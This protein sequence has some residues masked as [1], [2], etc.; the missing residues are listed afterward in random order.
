L[1]LFNFLWS[2][3]LQPLSFT[4]FRNSRPFA[5]FADKKS[6]ATLSP[7]GPPAIIRRMVEQFRLWGGLLLCLLGFALAFR[8]IGNGGILKSSGE[9]VARRKIAAGLFFSLTGFAGAILF[10]AALLR[11]FR[12]SYSEAMEEPI[13]ATVWLAIL[14]L[15]AFVPIA[16]MKAKT[17]VIADALAVPLLGSMLDSAWRA[18]WGGNIRDLTVGMIPSGSG[19]VF[20]PLIALVSFFI[21]RSARETRTRRILFWICVSLIALLLSFLPELA[22]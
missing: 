11:H 8:V 14:G 2:F 18:C 1:L 19:L 9:L 5:Q 22:V 10:D 7:P 13:A 21:L 15:T 4:P 17:P 6:P 12:I 20:V 3:Y 16:A